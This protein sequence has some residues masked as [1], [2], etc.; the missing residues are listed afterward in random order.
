MSEFLKK[1]LI[2]G[3]SCVN[4]RLVFDTQILLNDKRDEKV[5]FNLEIDGEKQA[6]RISRKI[7]KMDEN[8]Q[9]EQ[10]MTKPLSYCCIKKQEHLPSLLEFNKILH[11]ISH[12][13]K[14][15]HLLS[16]TSNFTIKIQ[17][18]CY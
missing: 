2:G 7:L 4:T 14:I 17:K 1:T 15:G 18:L 12:E 6:K 16:L 13:D 8:N 11:K 9:Y 10:A 5:L 3:F